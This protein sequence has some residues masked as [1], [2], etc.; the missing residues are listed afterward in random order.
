[1]AKGR[2]WFASYLSQINHQLK[3]KSRCLNAK[4]ALQGMREIKELNL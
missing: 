1:V 4:R 2:A 3:Q